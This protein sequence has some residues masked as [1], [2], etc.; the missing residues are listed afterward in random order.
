[1][2]D[3]G[4][5]QRLKAICKRSFPS[6]YARYIRWQYQRISLTERIGPLLAS[7]EPP[8]HYDDAFD[9]LQ[10]SH[11]DWEG[12]YGYDPHSTWE[13]GS[14]RAIDLLTREE[15]R[16]PG[17]EIFE[18][19][20]GEG[21]TSYALACYGHQVTLNDIDDWRDARAK[22]LPFVAGNVCD[23]LPI[24]PGS[25]DLVISYNAFEHIAEP[26][27]ALNELV[28]LCKK[29]GII[30]L[31][32]SPLYCS[33][34][35]LHAFSFRMPYPQFLF[36]EPLIEAKVREL[37]VHD[38]GQELTALQPVNGWRLRQFR[39]LWQTSGCDV[40]S[41]VEGTD[42]KHLNTV[43]DFPK[44]FRGRGLEVEDLITSGISVTLRKT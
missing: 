14:R 44:A 37:T 20:C 6:A 19:G 18:A 16:T 11:G 3:P 2:N 28:R 27:T 33:P 1:M 39:Q 42:E 29:G 15:L 4:S 23:R 21:M 8:Q 17:L 5:F 30:H 43:M 38:L 26:Q 12:V 24:K 35:G 41:L 25:F 31:E 9:R 32:F 7:P 34:L 10:A 36:S 13:R 22:H 40:L